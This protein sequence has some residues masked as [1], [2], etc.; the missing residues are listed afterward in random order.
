MLGNRTS[1]A[2][3]ASRGNRF[4]GLVMQ[5]RRGPALTILRILEGELMD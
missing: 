4:S 5:R 1:P 2:G 3:I